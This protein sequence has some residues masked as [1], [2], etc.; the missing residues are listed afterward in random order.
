MLAW[1][2]ANGGVRAIG[3]AGAVT[4]RTDD[5][6]EGSAAPATTRPTAE[7]VTGT[8]RG[9]SVPGEATRLA[10]VND[11][12]YDL[13]GGAVLSEGTY[14]LDCRLRPA[15]EP[16]AGESMSATIRF[17]GPAKVDP[18]GERLGIAFPGR[19]PVTLGFTERRADPA[20][21][22]VPETPAGVATA[23]THLAAAH[24][25]MGPDRSHPSLRDHPP[26]VE[27][28]PEAS[29]PDAV[30]EAT[31]ETGI[32]LRLPASLEYLFVAAPLAY[33]LGAEVSVG[34]R[35]EPVLA[36]PET[37]VYYRF[38]PLPTF[39]HGVARLLRHV[40]FLDT[41]VRDVDRPTRGPLAAEFGLDAERMRELSPAA[42]LARYF[43]VQ[44]DLDAALPEWHFSTY[45]APE[46]RNVSAL[47]YLLDA[48]SLVYLPESSELR[49]TE[50]LERTLDDFYRSGGEVASTSAMNVVSPELQAGR[51][52]AWLAP[53]APID[54]FKTTRRAYENRRQ[55]RDRGTP[56]SVAVVLNDDAMAEEHQAVSDI[57]R[58]RAA[59]LPLSVTVDEHLT[60]EELADTF[61]RP[62]DFVHYIGHCD[63]RGLKCADGHLATDS[64]E[65]VR[66]RTFFLNACGSYDEG[67]SL[68]DA[69][70]VGGAVTLT[71]VLDRQAATV[72][73]AFARLLVNGFGLEPAMQ[74]S[75]RRIMMGK[76]YVVVGDGTYTLAP[77]A[78]TPVVGWLSDADGAFELTCESLTGRR[79]GTTF[80]PPFGD[81]RVLHGD[82][83]RTTLDRESLRAVLSDASLPVIY[84]NEFYWS[85]DLAARLTED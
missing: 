47:P 76:D 33:Y 24:R 50:L 1:V 85:D 26:V 11:R 65:Q 78:G 28:G 56:L 42:R 73:T 25:T 16:T 38:R 35:D 52:H 74:L 83:A 31:P 46:E 54:A 15:S 30:V 61:A 60:R 66:T 21:V 58:D 22:A 20:T 4:V 6:R 37:G 80:R 70:A 82:A 17:D 43:G 45:L 3:D 53:G 55:Y 62:N 23:L 36:A 39:Q 64:L 44:G 8:V 75:R 67:L 48:L 63:E 7:T 27:T 68:V 49:G 12:R 32:E 34:D 57:Y 2:A 29:I 79:N 72:G 40:F 9:L 13:Q 77:T 81:E 14:R 5:W 69:G 51:V 19:T 59:D 41:L 18:G 10:D 71:K 84:E